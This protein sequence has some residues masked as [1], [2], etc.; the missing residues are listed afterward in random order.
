MTFSTFT[1]ADQ[2]W[3]V[4]RVSL[5]ALLGGCIGFERGN[6]GKSAGIRTHMLVAASSALAVGL[7]ELARVRAGTGDPTR[8]MHAVVTG[9]GFIGGG[10]IYTMKRARGPYGLTSAATVV[11]V[12]GIGM[13]AGAGAPLLAGAGTALT[14]VTLSGVQAIEGRL[15]LLRSTEEISDED[16][17]DDD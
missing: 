4:A 16:S 15:R 8:M 9:I 3:L 11:L 2:A 7:G 5:A 6:A 10:M 17:V 12:A 14:L 13:A 1:L